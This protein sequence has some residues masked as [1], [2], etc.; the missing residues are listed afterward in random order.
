MRKLLLFSA[1]L[2]ALVALLVFVA[3][4]PAPDASAGPE[5]AVRPEP[6]TARA[7]TSSAPDATPP[8][9]DGRV[10]ARATA[11][12]PASTPP[13]AAQPFVVRGR[14]LDSQRFALAGATVELLLEG[15]PVFRTASALDGSFTFALDDAATLAG[16]AMLWAHHGRE[17]A[18]VRE[19]W[20]PS[21]ARAKSLAG[22]VPPNDARELDVGGVALLAASPLEVSVT[23]SGT[24]LAGALVALELA[25]ATQPFAQRTT[26]SGGMARFEALPI[27]ALRLSAVAGDR[28]GGAQAFIPDD[29]VARIEVGEPRELELVVLDATTRAPIAAARVQLDERVWLSGT[30]DPELRSI[31]T[32]GN[33]LALR[34]LALALTDAEGR[35]RVR[36]AP[37]STFDLSVRARGYDPYPSKLTRGPKLD[38]SA[39]NV[40]VPLTPQA[41]RTLRWPIVAGEVPLPADG[42]ELALRPAPG[43]R[44][45]DELT[46]WP[47]RGRVEGTFAIVEGNPR[48]VQYIAATPDGAL[49]QLVVASEGELGPEIRFRRAR[50]IEV[51]VR[52]AAG[53]P[54]HG[55]FAVARN[56]GNNPLCGWVSTDAEGRAV[57]TGLYGELCD[58]YVAPPGARA[59][60]SVCGT[61]DLA[62]GDG[63]VEAL[64][65]SS[66][67]LRLRTWID[68]AAVLPPKYAVSSGAGATVVEE[69]PASGELRVRVDAG[70]NP[71]ETPLHLRALGFLP[72][73]VM[74]SVP[75]D[76][77]EPSYDVQLER[78]ARLVVRVTGPE[79][80]RALSVERFDLD[81]G[82]WKSV[83][84]IQR[85]LERPNGSRGTFVFDGLAAGR[86]R[87]LDGVAKQASDEVE[88]GNGVFEAQVELAIAPLG[89]LS[90]RVLAPAG[91]D[92]ALV[93]LLSA[94]VALEPPQKLAPQPGEVP[95]GARVQSDGAFEL[96]LPTN[97]ELTLR[98][99]HPWLSPAV[100]AGPLTVRAPRSGIVLRLESADLVRVPLASA[101]G[102]LPSSLRVAA[103]RGELSNAP[104]QWLHAH[105]QDDVAS[106][107]GLAPGLWT[108]WLDPGAPL[109]PLTLSGVE[110][111]A[112]E[113]LAPRA[114]FSRGLELRVRVLTAE[115]E[116]TPRVYIDAACTSGP[117]YRRSTNSNGEAE[118]VLAGFD[119]GTFELSMG[120]V[121]DMKA[122]RRSSVTL[123]GPGATA[124]EFDPR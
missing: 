98:A 32:G 65:P 57:L 51:S 38:L 19:V 77:R 102:P 112:G 44:L 31:S 115:G 105:V 33:V 96:E 75:S 93:R 58:V 111:L 18:G 59:A 4:A 20:L 86:Y 104:D 52:D 36:V 60:G 103:F 28:R 82:V 35:A 5:A 95:L 22:F 70:P 109:A 9:P 76:A 21:A 99:W 117:S 113:T 46:P 89:K 66:G 71:L 48:F 29:V 50:Q 7:S 42:T 3:R 106:F 69:L 54:V 79:A 6:D 63:R 64:L 62:K 123:S 68:G 108:L 25:S 17:L 53:R 16:H 88:L 110:V 114:V 15:A 107:T 87:A 100:G 119:A 83:G 122:L 2:A 30:S 12:A 85:T 61:V 56:Q 37:D 55:A 43:F 116:A 14:T 27:G 13:V 72:T 124:V 80:K 47:T 97:L 41:T 101:A 74:V 78:G 120:S 118:V 34:K 40:E 84:P 81:A 26:D 24:P 92:F 8:A 11:D 49:A 73:T 94:E 91:T 23:A 39:A 121:M 45:D 67:T 1:L 90:G 10:D